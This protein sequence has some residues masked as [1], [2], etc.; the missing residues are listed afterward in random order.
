LLLSQVAAAYICGITGIWLDLPF[1]QECVAGA[2][3]R[4]GTGMQGAILFRDAEFRSFDPEQP[5]EEMGSRHSPRGLRIKRPPLATRNPYLRW[6]GGDA[7]IPL[8]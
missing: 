4:V 7:A 8:I 1:R 3:A 5:L 2:A 6:G